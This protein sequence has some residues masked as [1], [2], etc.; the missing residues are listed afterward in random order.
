ME[1]KEQEKSGRYGK[2]SCRRG[3][4][5]EA[6]AAEAEAEE[7]KTEEVS[8]E[9]GSRDRGSEEERSFRKKLSSARRIR[10]TKRTRRSKN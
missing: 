3:K 4:E 2:R 1:D 9:A 10:K 6:E 7:A 8:E 5:P